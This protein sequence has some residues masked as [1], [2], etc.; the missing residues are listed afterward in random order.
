MNNLKT[1][2]VTSRING[3]VNKE[4]MAFC[5]LKDWEPSKAI[6]HIIENFFSKENKRKAA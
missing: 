4:L 3:T 2:V 1:Y 6:R 5:K